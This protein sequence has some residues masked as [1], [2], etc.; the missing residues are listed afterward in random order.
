[1]EMFTRVKSDSASSLGMALVL[2]STTPLVLLDEDL[3]VHAASE[4]FCRAFSLDCKDVIGS[5]MFALGAGE[6]DIPQ[7]RSLVEATA[8]GRAAIDAYEFD[9]KRPTQETRKLL[10]N[11]HMLSLPEGDKPFIV[12]AV[13][14]VTEARKAERVKDDLVREKQL[15][16]LELQHRVANSLQIIASVLMQSV[17]RVQSEETRT[18]LRDAHHRVMSIAT[19]QRQ[20]ARGE[21]DKVALGPYFKDLC[22]S[23]GASM[24]GDPTAVRLV[25]TADDTVTTSADSVSLGLI[26]TELVINC[27]KHAFDEKTTDGLIE[28]DYRHDGAGWSLT[29]TDNGAGLGTDYDPAK[30]G[31]GTGIVNALARQL[32]AEVSMG[33]STP[34]TRV[35][36]VH[37]APAE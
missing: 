33:S 6:W 11:A 30:G 14:D 31:L 17:R 20:L 19:L 27:L 2:S 10:L 21:A 7:F 5:P 24:I 25:V 23:I 9:L 4:S 26:V 36:I 29:V 18:H 13:S 15:L 8:A 28:V 16:L 3:C 34:G 22:T 37:R 1:M 12:L 32:K 35:A